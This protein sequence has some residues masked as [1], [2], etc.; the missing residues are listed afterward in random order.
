MVL[1]DISFI[2]KETCSHFEQATYEYWLLEYVKDNSEEFVKV[3][4]DILE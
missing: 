1:S 2:S 3:R 4:S